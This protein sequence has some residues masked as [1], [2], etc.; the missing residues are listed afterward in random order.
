M[1]ALAASNSLL[2]REPLGNLRR[3]S[4]ISSSLSNRIALC[5]SSALI[6]L[7]I[8][9]RSLCVIITPLLRFIV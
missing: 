4:L 3:F 8:L 2:A 7:R 9:F 5:A 1:D 6:A